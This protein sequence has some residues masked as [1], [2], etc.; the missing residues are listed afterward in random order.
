MDKLSIYDGTFEVLDLMDLI[1]H[2]LKHY[3]SGGYMLSGV[4]IILVTVVNSTGRKL[5]KILMMM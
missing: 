2:D 5:F 1:I 3:S 4:V